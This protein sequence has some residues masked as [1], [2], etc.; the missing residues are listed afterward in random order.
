MIETVSYQGSHGRDKLWSILIVRMHH[1]D[2]V[3]G[4]LQGQPVAGFL[5][6]AVSKIFLVHIHF[7]IGQC[8]RDRCSFITA[9]V[10]DDDNKVHN[11][12]VHDFFIGFAQRV[13]SVIGRHDDNYFL[14]LIH[15]GSFIA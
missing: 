10:I 7:C 15:S 2:N 1:D 14:S 4:F 5:I 11:A 8:T 12:L 9:A 6:R 3:T 13:R